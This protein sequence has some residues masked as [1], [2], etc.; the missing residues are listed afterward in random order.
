MENGQIV[1]HG[2]YE[3]VAKSNQLLS[4]AENYSEKETKGL[5]L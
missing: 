1:D 4:S 5:N 3:S 2:S